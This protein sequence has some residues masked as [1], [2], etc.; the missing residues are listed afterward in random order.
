MMPRRQI[1]TRRHALAGLLLLASPLLTS[2]A[3]WASDWPERTIRMFVP[4]AARPGA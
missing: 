2:T 1:L 4:F 3:A